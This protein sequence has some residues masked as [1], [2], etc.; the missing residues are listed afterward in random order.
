[1]H[2]HMHTHACMH[3]CIRTIAE[4]LQYIDDEVCMYVHMYTCIRIHACTRTIAKIYSSKK[5]SGQSFPCIY[6]RDHRYM[7]NTCTNMYI[8]TDHRTNVMHSHKC[9][10]IAINRTNA[11]QGTLVGKASPIPLHNAVCFCIVYCC[12]TI[13]NTY[14]RTYTNTCVRTYTNTYTNTCMHTDHCT[15]AGQ[16]KGVG[17]ASPVPRHPVSCRMHCCL[18]VPPSSDGTS[19]YP[20][21]RF[22][23]KGHGQCG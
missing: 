5:N 16:E 15:D 22:G 10:T 19:T 13:T 3:A 11:I 4:F 8:H 20:P 12:I 1:M 6:I 17:R 23:A 21:T 14:V 18:G 9:H 7:K 2:V